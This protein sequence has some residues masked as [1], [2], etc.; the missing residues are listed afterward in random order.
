[1]DDWVDATLNMLGN[2]K[3][4]SIFIY[5]EDHKLVSTRD[6]LESVLIDFD[7]QGLD[8]LCY[9]WFKASALGTENLLPLNP[10]RGVTL[11]VFD[12]SKAQNALIGKISPGYYPFSLVSISSVD[13][14]KSIMTSCNTRFK[15]Y[16]KTATALLS[17][18]YP[19]PGNRRV[20]KVINS[21]VSNCGICFC[22]Y[23]PD[24][25]FNIEK[26]W[27]DMDCFQ[28][29]W[30][31]G[32]L[33]AELYAN[34]DDDNGPYGESL[35]KRGLYPFQ[36]RLEQTHD[37]KKTPQISFRVRLRNDEMYDCTYFSHRGRISRAPVVHILVENGKVLVTCQSL[38]TIL[39]HGSGEYFY[40]NKS[41]VVHSLGDSIITLRIFD[42]CF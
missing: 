11:H 6:H 1:E 25:P 36:P 22:L 29:S 18:L 21:L 9:S 30:K 32:I 20:A 31:F 12:Y 37:A 5:F 14:L 10:E 13:Y 39:E 34:F 23:P 17:R 38:E 42:E 8:Y 33:A 27:L 35:I 40:T 28:R 41:L 15:F 3:S 26:S 16:S 19:Y 24:S 4:R 2:I 7:K